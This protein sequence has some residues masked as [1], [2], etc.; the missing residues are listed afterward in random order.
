LGKK[1]KLNVNLPHDNKKEIEKELP[2]K[3][4]VDLEFE[5]KVYLFL[6]KLKKYKYA[7]IGLF[8]AIL[9]GTV[10][11]YF[12]E[13]NLEKKKAEA[14]LLAYEIMQSYEKNKDKEIK[15]KIEEFKK[16]YGD[17]D[18]IKLVLTYEYLI[19]KENDKLKPADVDNLLNKLETENLKSYMKEFKAYLFYKNKKY[20]NALSILNTIT[21]K[22]FNY[23]SAL[24]LKAVVL[25]EKGDPKYKEILKQVKSLA[26]NPYF[27]QVAD[28]LLSQKKI[29]VVK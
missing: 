3:E 26:K 10:G 9:L 11:Y 15:K 21:Q 8:V 2:L 17:T 1:K 22:D 20:D 24:M 13:K 28:G 16:K 25:K 4:D 19:K 6:E 23:I 5:L 27:K 29:D 7:L 18:Y 12:Y 14:S